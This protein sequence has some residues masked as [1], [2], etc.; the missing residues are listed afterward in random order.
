M[1]GTDCKIVEPTPFD[2]SWFSHKFRSAGV[3][4]EIAVS[5]FTGYIVWVHGP[6]P[7]GSHI[8]LKIFELKLKTMLGPGERVIADKGY[9]DSRCDSYPSDSYFPDRLFATCRAR[10]ENANRRIKQF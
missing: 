4:Y 3:R 8:D 2:P 6:Y 7:C 5:V 1:E 10:H 9:K